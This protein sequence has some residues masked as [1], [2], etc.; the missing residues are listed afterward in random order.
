MRLV[1]RKKQF[2]IF[3]IIILFFIILMSSNVLARPAATNPIDNPDS[4]EPT[5]TQG[6][7]EALNMANTI[8]GTI[9][10]VGTF[11]SVAT[12]VILG[13][14]YMVGSTE[15]K[16]EYKKTMLPYIIGAFLL[17]SGSNIVQILYNIGT[18]L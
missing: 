12:L 10:T 1:K 16:A 11:V 6:Q 4:W 8:V 13:I 3:I 9:K 5:T 2:L 7:G 14:K 17:F 15:E 18:N